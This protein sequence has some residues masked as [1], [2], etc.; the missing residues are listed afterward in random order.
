MRTLHFFG[1]EKSFHG[2]WDAPYM[3]GGTG[4]LP[5]QAHR[6]E[7]CAANAKITL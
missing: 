3:I 2:A 4:I 5:V 7:A 6:L 1:Y